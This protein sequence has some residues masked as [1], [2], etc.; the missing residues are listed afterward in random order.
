MLQRIDTEN[1]RFYRTPQGNLYPSVTTI[2]SS[3]PNP[4]LEAWKQAV[5]PDEVARVSKRATDNGTRMH[6]FCEEYLQGK[7]PQL[8]VFQKYSYS[9]L[10]KILDTVNPIALEKMLYSDRLR[11]AGTLDCFAKFQGE[12]AIMDWKTTSKL[13]HNGEFD[14]YWLQTSAYAAMIYEHLG[15]LVPSLVIVMQ[16][17]VAG[18]TQVFKERTQD[19]LPRFK[20]IRDSIPL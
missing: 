19:W 17:L 7:N 6:L 5:G 4:E 9:G 18:E 3:I 10:T 13:K 12:L 14:T 15:V 11:V 8:D 16:D 1:G 2:L 20:M